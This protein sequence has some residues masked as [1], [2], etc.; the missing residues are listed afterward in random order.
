[1]LDYRFFVL[2]PCLLVLGLTCCGCGGGKGASV[3]AAVAPFVQAEGEL[4]AKLQESLEAGDLVEAERIMLLLRFVQSQ[5]VLAGA[6]EFSNKDLMAF[7]VSPR[8]H[9]LL[10]DI[11]SRERARVLR[12]VIDVPEGDEETPLTTD[13]AVALIVKKSRDLSPEDWDERMGSLRNMLSD[14]IL[15]SLVAGQE[16][17]QL[18][19]R[20]VRGF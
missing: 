14:E 1:M 18:R 6:I 16:K 8:D 13:V 19:T 11:L 4:H 3:A 12:D 9:A 7:K 10:A 20:F 5:E 17:Y 15:H 2:Q